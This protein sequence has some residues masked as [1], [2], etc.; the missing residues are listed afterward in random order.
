[1]NKVSV[2]GS[3]EHR[4]RHGV[5]AL[6]TVRTGDILCFAVCTAYPCLWTKLSGKKPFVLI[7]NLILLFTYI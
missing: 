5:T 3:R 7:F 2:S 6:P 1:M 4:D